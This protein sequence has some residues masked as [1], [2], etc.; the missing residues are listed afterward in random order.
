MIHETARAH[1][2]EN[3]SESPRHA[4]T[5]GPLRRP[6]SVSELGV[7]KPLLEDLALKILYLSGPFSVLDVAKH[8]RIGLPVADELVH[9]LRTLQLCEVTGMHGNVADIAITSQ[10]RSRA[11]ELLS[12]GQYADAAPISLQCYVRYVRS[13]SV[14]NVE[15]HPPDVESAFA[16]LVLDSKILWQIGT[17][18]NSGSSIFLHGP[19]GVGKTTIAETLSRVVA[20]DA[21][22][23]PYALE[24]NG[25][26]I[27]VYD[28]LIHKAVDA[29]LSED[30]DQRW[31]RCHRP[32]VMV[33]GEL[34]MD[35]LNLQFD[36]I[37]KFYDAPIQMK[38]NNGVLI[39]DDFG[40]QRVRPEELLNR[41]IV[42]L[43]RGIDFL[44]LAGGKKFE[45]PFEML[46]VFA[47]NM[48]PAKLVDAAFLRRIQTKIKVGVISDEQ[49]CEIFRR[50]VRER[51][52]ECDA[53][54]LNDLVDIIRSKLHQALRPCFPRDIVNQ[55]CWAARYEG[56]QPVLDHASVMRAVENYFLNKS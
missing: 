29:P 24:V 28:P 17:A 30:G 15:V 6:K 19:T 25:Q 20:E 11:L 42:P 3:S 21:V 32:V 27:A 8:M 51:G 34:S 16:H 33:G 13:Q 14:R 1:E 22:W 7:R 5:D 35:M 38:A 12:L 9:R 36:P 4:S 43:D 39:I 49:F 44:K 23:I 40:R 54:M 10:G 46:V 47:T 52:L 26:I 31:I 48:D 2:Q 56:K 41:W 18:L 37:A 55:I 50:V 53:N 45:I